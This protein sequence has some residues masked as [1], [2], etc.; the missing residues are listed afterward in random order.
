M[1]VEGV[2]T[3]LIP[4][5]ADRLRPMAA[6]TGSKKSDGRLEE[7]ELAPDPRGGGDHGDHGDWQPRDWGRNQDY[8]GWEDARPNHVSQQKTQAID[9]HKRAVQKLEI[10]REWE[11]LPPA[12]V[13]QTFETWI[14]QV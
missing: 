11:E 5:V 2:T 8:Q 10:G 4:L 6:A 14:T 3:L 7:V 9:K 12:M 1:G 13:H